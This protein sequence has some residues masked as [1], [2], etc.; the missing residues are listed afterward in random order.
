M[1]ELFQKGWMDGGIFFSEHI[2]KNTYIP[3]QPPLTKN[4]QG[5]EYAPVFWFSVFW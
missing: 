4:P 5:I 3:P 2:V 1:L